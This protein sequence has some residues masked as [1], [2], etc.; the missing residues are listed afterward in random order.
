[1]KFIE[2]HRALPLVDALYE[3]GLVSELHRDELYSSLIEIA[4]S[5]LKIYG[6][7]LPG[8]E[9]HITDDKDDVK[10]RLFELRDQFRHIE[11]HVLDARL[12]DVEW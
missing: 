9:A 10:D 5:I 1:M 12:T 2:E 6:A 11:T 3:R 7:I 4:T 8:I